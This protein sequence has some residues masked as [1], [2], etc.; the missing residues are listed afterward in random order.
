MA[1]ALT[2]TQNNQTPETRLIR[3]TEVLAAIVLLALLAGRLHP[4]RVLLPFPSVEAIAVNLKL[5]ILLHRGIPSLPT[6][7]RIH[8]TEEKVHCKPSHVQR[9]KFVTSL[10]IQYSLLSCQ[11]NGHMLIICQ[12]RILENGLIIEHFSNFVKELNFG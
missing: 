9:V 6:I 3:P 7:L 4:T 1:W 10:D 8:N 12:Q 2:T 5:Q 11:P